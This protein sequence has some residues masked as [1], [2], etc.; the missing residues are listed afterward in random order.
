MPFRVP[1]SGPLGRRMEYDPASRT[2]YFFIV[3]EERHLV[4]V[5]V[6]CVLY[7]LA[8]HC[9][10]SRSLLVVLAFMRKL[11]FLQKDV[12]VSLRSNKR[13]KHEVTTE[14]IPIEEAAHP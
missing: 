6:S 12:F 9:T 4:S 2:G 1:C 13:K 11:A 7:H 3:S 5:N 8:Q 14:M 10:S